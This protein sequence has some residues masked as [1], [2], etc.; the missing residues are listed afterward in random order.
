VSKKNNKGAEPCSS[1]D[2]ANNASFGG[3]VI[4]VSYCSVVVK[5]I[6]LKEQKEQTKAQ[7]MFTF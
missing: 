7:E 4:K 5:L 1:P 6:V 2:I 3:T